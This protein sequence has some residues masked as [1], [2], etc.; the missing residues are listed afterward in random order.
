MIA[1]ASR[2]RRRISRIANAME[3]LVNDDFVALGHAPGPRSARCSPSAMR[4]S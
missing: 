3:T 4:L 1:L 2:L